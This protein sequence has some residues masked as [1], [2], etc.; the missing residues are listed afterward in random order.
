MKVDQRL[1][2]ISNNST[3]GFPVQETSKGV[4][5]EALSLLSSG[6]TKESDAEEAS[7]FKR[8]FV[9]VGPILGFLG[10]LM[11]MG[12]HRYGKFD[13]R[14]KTPLKDVLV[15][16]EKS[17]DS[18][19][20]SLKKYG[21]WLLGIGNGFVSING[22]MAGLQSGQPGMLV[23]NLFMLPTSL[24]IA[25]AQ[26]N[27]SLGIA[28]TIAIFLGGMYTMGL[29]NEFPSALDPD[30]EPIKYDMSNLQEA[31]SLSSDMSI[32]DRVGT[33]VRD[34]FGMMKFVGGD[35]IRLIKSVSATA[36]ALLKGAIKGAGNIPEIASNPG[37]L[38]DAITEKDF[39]QPYQE[40]SYLSMFCAYL[41][42]IPLVFTYL[43]KGNNELA[44]KI[45]QNHP[46]MQLLR[47]GTMTFS[48]VALFNLALHRKDLLGKTP[49][50]GVPMSIMGTAMSNSPFYV[51]LTYVGENMNNL[52]F[53]QVA[54]DGKIYEN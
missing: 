20:E 38:V 15:G 7:A 34:F 12:S 54:V 47:A 5:S 36:F 11:M 50:L 4:S 13:K 16:K 25:R 45:V 3:V 10:G 35:H 46:A 27:L 23:N 17:V 40:L 44:L 30:K 21:K 53:S 26:S 52:L 14:M 6:A 48:N 43:T 9:L 2:P 19:N 24:W 37:G 29:A 22:L 1:T 39:T 51:G 41:S 8:A 28:H 32:G 42:T 18:L 33:A 31:L 49:L